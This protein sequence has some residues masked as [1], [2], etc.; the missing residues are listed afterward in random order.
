MTPTL[1]AGRKWKVKDTIISAK[2]NL[3]FKEVNGLTHTGRQGLGV[4]EKKWWS[5]ANGKDRRD[6]K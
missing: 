5:Q 2:E 4:N 6:R 3:A 1:K